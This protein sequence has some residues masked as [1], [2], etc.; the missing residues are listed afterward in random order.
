LPLSL[1]VELEKYIVE[2]KKKLL[3]YTKQ[4]FS[5]ARKKIKWESY[6]KLNDLLV[7]E[8]YLH[9]Y[10]TYKGYRLL[11]IDRTTIDIP[12]GKKNKQVFGSCNNNDSLKNQA[13]ST[14]VY[15][16]V[17]KFAV[18]ISLDKNGG[19]EREEAIKLITELK[20]KGGQKKDILVADRGY[21]SLKFIV[22]LMIMDYDYVIRCPKKGFIKEVQQFIDDE[23]LEDEVLEIDLKGRKMGM[24]QEK[25]ESILD[26]NI[27]SKMKLRVVKIK[28]KTGETEYLLT[29][30]TNKKKF[31]IEDFQLIYKSRWDEETCFNYIKHTVE[32]ENFSSK[33]PEFIKQDFFSRIVISNLHSLIIEDSQVDVDEKTKDNKRYKYAQYKVN[34]N[35]TYGIMHNK[36]FHLFNLEDDY[37]IK[38]YNYLVSIAKRFIISVRGNRNFPRDKISSQKYPINR[39]RAV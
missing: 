11:G 20:S 14:L 39:R 33:N 25:I 4:A 9:K 3:N 36:F 34:K 18:E 23:K 6:K 12:D 2:N 21:P 8:Y 28:L 26:T 31:R 17:N 35:V 1:S 38:I 15:D 10:K 13:N 29:S 37:W 27:K 19:G 22:Q 5:K 7:I 24:Y 30:L 32:I 16:L